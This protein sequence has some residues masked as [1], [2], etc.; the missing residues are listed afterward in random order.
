MTTAIQNKYRWNVDHSQWER[1]EKVQEYRG[2]TIQSLST[3]DDSHTVYHR[4]YRIT[5]PSGLT[6]DW[7]INK[8]GGNIK[9]L[10][11]WIDFN[12][13]HNRTKYL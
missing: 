3:H 7:T 5:T 10:R 1:V 9:E 6:S 11:K 4:V 8:R 13:E 2:H 12:I